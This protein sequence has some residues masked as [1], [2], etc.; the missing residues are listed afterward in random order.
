MRRISGE[1]RRD[2]L[3]KSIKD[4]A[5]CEEFR[6]NEDQEMEQ[7]NICCTGLYPESPPLVLCI[8]QK[9]TERLYYSR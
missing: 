8:A 9:Y 6:K 7:V 2:K 3:N 1:I 4:K 5:R